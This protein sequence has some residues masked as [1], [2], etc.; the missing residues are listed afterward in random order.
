MQKKTN[1]ILEELANVRFNKDPENFVE[2]RASHIIDSAINL[3]NYIRENFDSQTA[4]TLE[5]KFNS[6]IKNLDSKKFHRGVNRLKELKDVKK[7]LTV[8][9]GQYK[10]DE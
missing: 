4:Y 9:Q 10:E 8:K 6:A 5:K 3:V 2:S 7:S 1:S